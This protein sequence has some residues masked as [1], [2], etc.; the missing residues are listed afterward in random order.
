MVSGTSCQD[1]RRDRRTDVGRAGFRRIASRE[2]Q[3]A[4]RL[5][6]RIRP[7]GT[8][9]VRFAEAKVGPDRINPTQLRFV[10]LALRFH[11][12]EQF[13]IIEVAGP[14]LRGAPGRLRGSAWEAVERDMRRPMADQLRSNRQASCDRPRGTCCVSLTA[15]P[16]RMSR[17]RG[18]RCATS[19]QLSRRG[20]RTGRRNDGHPEG[21][22]CRASP[23]AGYRGAAARS[24]LTSAENAAQAS[25]LTI[26]LQMIHGPLL[27][28]LCILRSA[29]GRSPVASQP[30]PGGAARVSLLPADGRLTSSR[31]AERVLLL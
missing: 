21:A 14:S 24:F 4:P 1:T 17:K 5:L 9:Q 16:G 20:E 22:A 27:V 13:T 3:N 8:R 11:R 10:D 6:R 23:A 12:L 25:C 19:P 2:R 18:W 28:E 30:R 15:W 29:V 26:V 31:L 7:A